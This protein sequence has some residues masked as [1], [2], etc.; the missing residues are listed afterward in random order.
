MLEKIKY[1]DNT[2]YFD[3]VKVSDIAKLYPTPLYVYSKSRIIENYKL[4][5][6]NFKKN[7]IN[8]YCIHYAIKANENF[9]ILKLL[10]QLGAGV[11]TV[12]GN[13]IKK[14][15]LAGVSPD[16]I[17]FSGVSK[18]EEEIEYAI[19][20]RIGQINIESH[21][22]FLNIK[23]KA[24]QMKIVANISVR[25]NPDIDAETHEKITTGKKENK[26]GVKLQVAEKIY[27]ETNEFLNFKGLSVHIGSQILKIEKFKESL[28]YLKE[29][30]TK[31]PQWTTVDFGGGLGIEYQLDQK[32]PSK[33]DFIKLIKEYFFDYEGKI[34]IEPGRSIVGDSGIFLTKVIYTKE[35]DTKNFIMLDGGMNSLIRPALYDAYHHPLLAN[36]TSNEMK[37]YDIV[38]NICESGDIFCKD[39]VFNVPSGEN[40]IVF[41]SSGAYGRS[42]ASNYNLHDIVGEVWINE[43]K[44]EQIRKAI[45]FED[46]LKF[47]EIN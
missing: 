9:N 3:E 35:T 6:L 18:S 25:V 36:I 31:Y 47:E 41:L 37:K 15:L 4:Y 12:S 11:D 17:V 29:I 20:N 13:E 28:K 14:S 8:N 16:K 22:E 1:I 24:T 19:K 21:E 32:A 26:F 33:D 43:G 23:K 45:T 7:N 39:I 5:D 42:M 44:I 38:G 10:I 27:K 30:Y 46:L 40:Y 2:L 34:M